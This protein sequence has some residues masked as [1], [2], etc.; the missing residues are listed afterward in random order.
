[1]CAC[2]VRACVHVWWGVGLPKACP[3]RSGNNSVGTLALDAPLLSAQ[4]TLATKVAAKSGTVR[5]LAP[6][7]S[8]TST[9]LHS[10]MRVTP[11]SMAA[12]PTTAYD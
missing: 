10:S 6:L 9:V 4:L 7:V 11:P 8:M 2:V 5:L 3:R 1:M 12:A